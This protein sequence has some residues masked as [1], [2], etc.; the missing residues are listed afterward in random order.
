MDPAL[1]KRTLEASQAFLSIRQVL[2]AG[3]SG[4]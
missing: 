4:K 2:R 1:V 3:D